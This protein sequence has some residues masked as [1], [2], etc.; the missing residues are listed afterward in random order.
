MRM[1]LCCDLRAPPVRCSLFSLVL[2]LRRCAVLLYS[3][4]IFCSGGFKRTMAE[5]ERLGVPQS[6][7][8]DADELRKR[9]LLLAEFAHEISLA[10]L[11]GLKSEGK[12]TQRFRSPQTL[13]VLMSADTLMRAVDA[14]ARPAA[15]VPNEQLTEIVQAIEEVRQMV[16][17][18]PAEANDELDDEI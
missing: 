3:M 7:Q 8:A 17:S 6:L 11:S 9:G 18:A 10:E 16:G 1:C 4:R 13:A 15:H 12:L 5:M 14:A 2:W